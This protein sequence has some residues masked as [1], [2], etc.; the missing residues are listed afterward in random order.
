MPALRLRQL[1]EM[2]LSLGA[3]D[4]L[5]EAGMRLK[6]IHTSLER[7]SHFRD[8]RD[9]AIA[10]F[11]NASHMTPTTKFDQMN[12]ALFNDRHIFFMF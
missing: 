7:K 12:L 4:S 2:Q 1:K 3:I 8:I 5:Y 9:K 10:T 6:P 11:Y